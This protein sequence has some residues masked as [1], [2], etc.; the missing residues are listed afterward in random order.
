[1]DL[2][3][4]ESQKTAPFEAAELAQENRWTVLSF[5]SAACMPVMCILDPFP[6]YHDFLTKS[7]SHGNW[8]NLACW[9]PTQW[10]ATRG[11]P[12]GYLLQ[13]NAF[14][15]SCSVPGLCSLSQTLTNSLQSPHTSLVQPLL[16]T[17]KGNEVFCKVRRS[18]FGTALHGAEH[19]KAIRNTQGHAN[20]QMHP[21]I[22]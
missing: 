10:L 14:F 8:K 11:L 2:L 15:S 7:G 9:L 12:S 16:L 5:L 6:P 19:C 13:A 4:R 22:Q 20:Q 21:V 17:S 1:M 18:I 3:Q